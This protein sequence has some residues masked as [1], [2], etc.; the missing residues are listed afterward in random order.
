MA[1]ATRILAV[2]PCLNEEKYLNGLVARLIEAN[3]D[4]PIRFVIAD[5]GSKDRS[6]DIAK[7]LAAQHP[8][9]LYLHNAKRHQSAAVNLAAAT[10]GEGAD[11][12]IR[13]DAHADYPADYCRALVAEAEHTG[14]D[15]VVTAMRTEG[16]NGF[17]RAVAAVQNSKLGNGGAAHRT[18]GHEGRW[19]DHGHHAL[20]RLAPFRAIGGYDETFT[21]NED[22]EFDTR[23]QRAGY[24][25]WLTGKTTIT[26]FP[27][28]NPAALFR[29][30][31][32]H[33]HGRARTILKHRAMPRLR[34]LA[35]AAVLPAALLALLG[36]I[37]ALP[38]L[39]WIAVCLGTGAVMAWR[40]R[41]AA[42]LLAGPAAMIMHFGW[43]LGFWRGAAEKLITRP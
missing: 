8:H 14:A 2:I 31:I 11:F 10:Y 30:Y 29:Q 20:I 27:R 38:L 4:Q 33:G 40:E 17:Q 42:L 32:K 41:N 25:I 22:A 21:H 7:N 5:G 16:K 6:V 39:I 28:D 9:I 26:Y 18:A 1:D 36:G 35:P 12:L 34:Q 15:S 37:A 23:F 43:S 3:R 24:K 19:V 13:I